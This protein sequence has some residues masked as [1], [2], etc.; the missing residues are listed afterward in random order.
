LVL[1]YFLPE[2]V[3][4][5]SLLHWMNPSREIQQG[6]PPTAEPNP[7]SEPRNADDGTI[8]GADIQPIHESAP[9]SLPLSA[10]TT[11]SGKCR[12]IRRHVACRTAGD[13]SPRLAEGRASSSG[14]VASPGCDSAVHLDVSTPR[15]LMNHSSASIR[16]LTG[17]G[18]GRYMSEEEEIRLQLKGEKENNLRFQR[19]LR[20][21]QKKAKKQEEERAK[22]LQRA[23]DTEEREKMELQKQEERTRRLLEIEERCE[24]KECQIKER[25]KQ[26]Q[27]DELRMD[28]AK[29]ACMRGLRSIEDVELLRQQLKNERLI[30]IRE[31]REQR[32]RAKQTTQL[33]QQELDAASTAEFERL[34]QEKE[35]RTEQEQL[36]RQREVFKRERND[37]L[38]TKHVE[39]RAEQERR[40]IAIQHQKEQL[41]L[42]QQEQDKEKALRDK[43]KEQGKREQLLREAKELR[44]QQKLLNEK[45]QTF[46]RMQQEARDK[47]H[48]IALER[49]KEEAKLRRLLDIEERQERAEKARLA[50]ES[51]Q[52][53][54]KHAKL[55]W[56]YGSAK[57]SVDMLSAGLQSLCAPESTKRCI[58]SANS[59]V[60]SLAPE[61][62]GNPVLQV[63]ESQSTE[64][65]DIQDQD[66]S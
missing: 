66:V 46:A 63:G 51:Q 4:M 23:R 41:N 50:R 21:E 6:T 20:E 24:W 49:R 39:M 29:A 14:C 56:D 8:N 11:T 43:L 3:S 59:H 31:D 2:S 57:H 54:A 26:K 1:P 7:D 55:A 17:T 58:D 33:L 48:R 5:E 34:K 10:R 62:E 42:L 22:A 37:Q 13:I 40:R 53:N 64:L 28:K 12:G 30:K 47:E 60:E 18:F 19:E 16:S 65:R 45:K 36:K 15:L 52:E 32:E 44:E 25:E 35:Q 9:Q 27:A 61:V 38:K